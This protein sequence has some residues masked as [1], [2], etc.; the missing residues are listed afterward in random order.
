MPWSTPSLTDVR[1]LTRDYVL[2]Q[3]GARS[4]IPNSVLR[5]MSDAMSGLTHLTLVYID[6]LSKQLLP[7]TAET[8]WLDRHGD[9]WLVNADGSTGRKGATLAHGFAEFTGSAGAIVPTGTQI[10]AGDTS[11]ETTDQIVLGAGAPTRAPVRALQPGTAGNLAD[12]SAAGLVVPIPGVDESATLEGL[13]GGT[14]TE[15]DDQLRARVLKRIQQPPM[16]GDATDY[17][18][19]ALAVPGVTRAWCG[20]LEMGIGTVTVRFLMD[21]LRADNDGWPTAQDIE[22]VSAY[23]ESKRPVAVKDCF[24]VAPIKQP[25]D[26]VIDNLDPDTTEVRNEI[27]ASIRDMLRTAAAPGQTIFVAWKNYAVLNV[28][29][30]VSFRLVNNEDDVMPSP[31]H[32]AI[33]GDIIYDDKVPLP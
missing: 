24:V 22:T 6:W 21:D 30:V 15:T 1:K 14:D 5:I 29:H 10:S 18:Q 26:F 27:E 4:M 31:G 17:E 7:D 8:E 11:Y 25:I 12:D 3:L 28:P 19:W 13:R 20:P 32:M 9:I 23:I 33:L 16:G 2:S